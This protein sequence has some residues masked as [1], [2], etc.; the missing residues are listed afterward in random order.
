L[1]VGTALKSSSDWADNNFIRE[2]TTNNQDQHPRS[3]STRRIVLPSGRSIEVIRFDETAPPPNEGLHVCPC[4][5]S[6]LVQP[7]EWGEVSRRHVELTLHCPNCS[8]SRH[9]IYDEELV[10]ELEDHLDDGV[11]AILGD[12][13]RLAN[14]NMADEIE[15]FAVALKLDVIL[16]EDF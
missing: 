12:L 11:T 13:R 2:G 16:P 15:R 3:Y 9:G 4:C 8:W 7:I 5:D 14:A 10:A 1:A 6:E